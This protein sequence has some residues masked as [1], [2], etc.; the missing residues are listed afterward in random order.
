MAVFLRVVCVT[1]VF[2]S[3]YAIMHCNR[4]SF[5]YWLYARVAD[6]LDCNR[7]PFGWYEPVPARIVLLLVRAITNIPA[8][9]AAFIVLIFLMQCKDGSIKWR[10]TE[11]VWCCI[12]LGM[13][14][15]SFVLSEML[16]R[17]AIPAFPWKGLSNGLN[18]D[19]LP[20]SAHWMLL[21]Y[22]DSL[23]YVGGFWV[24]VFGGLLVTRRTRPFRELR[25]PRCEYR[26][27]GLTSSRCPECGL[28]IAG[29]TCNGSTGS[30]A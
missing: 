14:V 28:P 15:L 4:P 29:A 22:L 26:L 13:F 17:L 5:E 24:A 6:G 12:S 30:R 3:T 7:E 2:C 16:L 10:K 20:M 19:T 8:F 25:C 1:F 23:L 18:K 27:Q 9:V 21:R 11:T